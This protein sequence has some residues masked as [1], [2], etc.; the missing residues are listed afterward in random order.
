[1]PNGVNRQVIMCRARL[2]D[3]YANFSMSTDH[4]VVVEILNSPELSMI[5]HFRAPLVAIGRYS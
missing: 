2:R 4:A 5:T 3:N 1:M